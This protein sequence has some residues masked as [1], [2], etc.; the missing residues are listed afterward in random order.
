MT[1]RSLYRHAVTGKVAAFN[2][3]VA[4]I[5]GDRLVEVTDPTGDVEAEAVT[6]RPKK[7]AVKKT[8]EDTTPIDSS[9]EGNE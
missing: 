3:R 5:F 6:P 8:S 9:K 1:N 2:D 4:A 7:R